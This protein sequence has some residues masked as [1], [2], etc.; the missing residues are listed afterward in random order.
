VLPV[1][2][3]QFI[4]IHLYD[5]R[6]CCSSAACAVQQ[7]AAVTSGLNHALNLLL[8]FVVSLL[9]SLLPC[10][11]WCWVTPPGVVCGAAASGNYVW[12]NP[13]DI[14]K[15][16][17]CCMMSGPFLTGY[18]QTINDYYD[19]EIDAINEPYRPIPSGK[20]LKLQ[21]L[22]CTVLYCIVLYCTVLYCTVLYCTVL[23]SS[24]PVNQHLLCSCRY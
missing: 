17:T 21:Q 2:Q 13:E 11:G 14:A 4:F 18:T 15:L 16:L 1:L 24:A 22:Y 19:R 12:N 20:I 6:P 10:A 23:P 3:P 5:Q 9:L 8:L 7:G